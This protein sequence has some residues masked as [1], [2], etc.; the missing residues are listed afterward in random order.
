MRGCC[1]EPLLLL[2]CSVGLLW[3]QRPLSKRQ[4]WIPTAAAAAQQI[5]GITPA[6]VGSRRLRQQ[7]RCRGGSSGRGVQETCGVSVTLSQPFFLTPWCRFSIVEQQ[8]WGFTSFC[9]CCFCQCCTATTYTPGSSGLKAKLTKLTVSPH[10][11]W[12]YAAAAQRKHRRF[13]SIK[14]T[15]FCGGRERRI[16]D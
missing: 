9:Q 12:T 5:P 15:R 4:V 14:R 16:F 3:R 2:K 8:H 7:R 1:R 13:K 6:S 10:S 11:T